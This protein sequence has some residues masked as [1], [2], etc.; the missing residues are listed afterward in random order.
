MNL[1]EYIEDRRIKNQLNFDMSKC[2]EYITQ[3]YT[4]SVA[5][6]YKRFFY[7]VREDVYELIHHLGENNLFELKVRGK[8]ET[9]FFEFECEEHYKKWLQFRKKIYA[10]INDL[11]HL[12]MINFL[13]LSLMNFITDLTTLQEYEIIAPDG[14]ISKFLK[15]GYGTDQDRQ[16]F[17]K[18]LGRKFKEGFTFKAK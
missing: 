15:T 2:E 7:F 16:S 8:G 5:D 1:H 9:P 10:S 14:T 3:K 4:D 6:V 17:I 11:K 12:R 18:Y 13:E